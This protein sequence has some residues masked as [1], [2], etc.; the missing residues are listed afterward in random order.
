[1]SASAHL[2]SVALVLILG[3]VA[4][5]IQAPAAPASELT[6]AYPVLE[7]TQEGLTTQ[8]AAGLSS[9]LRPVLGKGAAITDG[10]S[11]WRYFS[12]SSLV[13]GYT[14]GAPLP[15]RGGD[16]ERGPSQKSGSWNVAL[17]AKADTGAMQ[18][19]AAS[20]G[21]VTV[22]CRWARYVPALGPAPC[23][24]RWRTRSPR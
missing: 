17:L 12:P 23:D 6:Q 3:I 1:M 8:Q 19:A 10:E 21:K 14:F 24:C 13:S 16:D 11:A 7:V 15:K 9:S 2:R 4:V 18:A 5:G 20:F 22:P